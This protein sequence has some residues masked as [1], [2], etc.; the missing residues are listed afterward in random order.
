MSLRTA[1]RADRRLREAAKG[2]A[3]LAGDGTDPQVA[4]VDLAYLAIKVG[5]AERIGE[6]ALRRL[7]GLGLIHV[8]A[9]EGRMRRHA[10]A[11]HA[12]IQRVDATQT[13]TEREMAPVPMTAAQELGPRAAALTELHGPQLHG[14]ALLLTLGDQATAAQ[15]AAKALATGAARAREHEHPRRTAAWLRH[16]VLRAAKRRHTDTDDDEATRRVALEKLSVDGNAF[17]ALSALNVLERAA[18]VASN[19]ELLEPRDVATVVGLDEERTQRIVRD[20]VRRATKAAVAQ[21]SGSE[22]DGPMVT[23]IREI[24]AQALA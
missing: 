17:A 22:A 10:G 12:A 4:R 15:L 13:S 5:F 9:L 3:V 11:A 23:R 6:R 20:A 21:P 24:A 19:V 2:T 1:R 16:S 18:V 8:Q 7:T 14:F